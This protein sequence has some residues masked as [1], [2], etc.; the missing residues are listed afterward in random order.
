MAHRMREH[1]RTATLLETDGGTKMTDQRK[2]DAAADARS[3]GRILGSL[4]DALMAASRTDTADAPTERPPAP[5]QRPAAA[6]GPG[7]VK[8][9]RS[10][11][12]SSRFVL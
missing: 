5:A 10:A 9:Q 2:P 1:D 4:R 7:C 3:P 8:T 12:G 11:N 6:S